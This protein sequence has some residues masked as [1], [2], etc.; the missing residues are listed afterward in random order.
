HTIRI[1]HKTGAV[2]DL[3]AITVMNVPPPGPLNPGTYEDTDTNI[4]Y[5]AGWVPLNTS[6][7]TNNTL[8]YSTVTGGEATFQINS[9]RFTLTYTGFTNRGTAEIYVD[10]ALYTTL[11]QYSATLIWQ[12][13]W[14][15]GDLGPGPHTIRIVHKTGTYIDIDAI[16]VHAP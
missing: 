4:T 1:V 12:K 14:T 3:D 13:T 16:T 2:V 8:Y 5:T 6:G 15:S 7:P 10:G 9:N 11:N